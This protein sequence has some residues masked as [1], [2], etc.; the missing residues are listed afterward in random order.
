MQR[1][2]S[3]HSEVQ[4][5]PAKRATAPG[6]PSPSARAVSTGAG[7]GASEPVT[8]SGIS[9]FS[10][11][12][13]TAR[14]VGVQQ[15]GGGAVVTIE[16]DLSAM[17]SLVCD[18]FYLAAVS[19]PSGQF[20]GGRYV[21]GGYGTCFKRVNLQLDLP[22]DGENVVL[23]HWWA[24][25]FQPWFGAT[26]SFAEAIGADPSAWKDAAYTS[27]PFPVVS[28]Q[29]GRSRGIYSEPTPTVGTLFTSGAEGVSSTLSS[30]EGVLKWGSI[31]AGVGAAVWFGWPLLSAASETAAGAVQSAPGEKAP[32]E[33]KSSASS[34]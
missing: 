13:M 8:S 27:S 23:R 28:T 24:D 22:P 16:F 12:D 26:P 34:N 11:E 2:T 10:N 3:I 32:G 21:P 14:V 20:L 33:E 31:A 7:L 29:E 30:V 4:A 19:A 5:R 6:R 15:A 25:T 18:D 1:A 17:V 9:V